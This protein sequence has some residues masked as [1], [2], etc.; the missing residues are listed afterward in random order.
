MYVIEI[1]QLS[2]ALVGMVLC[3]LGLVQS[4]RDMYAVRSP[5]LAFARLVRKRRETVRFIKHSVMFLSGVLVVDWRLDRGSLPL[6][7][8]VY[9]TRNLT[10]TILSVLMMIETVWEQYDRWVIGQMVVTQPQPDP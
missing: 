4:S 8:Y 10:M 5:L 3:A 9:Y 7:F 1:V 6:D 2:A